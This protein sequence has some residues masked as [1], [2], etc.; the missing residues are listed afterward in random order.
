MRGIPL[1]SRVRLTAATALLVGLVAAGLLTSTPQ[2]SAARTWATWGWTVRYEL[3]PL[4]EGAELEALHVSAYLRS[5]EQ[6]VACHGDKTGSELPVHRI[7]LQSGLLPDLACQDCH[8]Q[9]DLGPRDNTVAAR[10]VDVGFC[11]KCHSEFPGLQP[12]SHMQSDDIDADCTMCHTGARAIRHAQPYLSQI[13]SPSECKGCH[14]GRVLPWTPE[15]EEDDWLQNHGGEALESGTEP[16]LDCHDFGLKFC[17]ECHAETPPSHLPDERWRDSHP[18]AAREDTRVCYTCHQT[19]FCKT[20]HVDHEVGWME[21]HSD[22][23]AEH[24]ESSCE[25]CHSPSSCSYCH[26]AVATTGVSRFPT[27]VP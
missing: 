1:R 22:F 12:G 8:Q 15:H 3:A 9:V 4:E 6:C 18:D 2:R 16:C 23:V 26:A 17:D 25:E 19:S 5:R 14:G 7:H 13:I 24:G 11:K 10:W 21:T 20:C 27:T